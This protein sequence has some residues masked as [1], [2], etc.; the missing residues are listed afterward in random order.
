MCEKIKHN[1]SGWK[2]FRD[3]D[4]SSI[5][6]RDSYQWLSIE[7]PATLIEK[8][9]GGFSFKMSSVVVVVVDFLN[10]LLV[11][12]CIFHFLT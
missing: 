6:V 11:R 1:N 12:K 3:Q 4:C 7:S 8:V 5:F 9:K 10:E 2:M